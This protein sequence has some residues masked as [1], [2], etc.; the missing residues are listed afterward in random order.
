M[1]I[2]KHNKT[3]NLYTIERLIIDLRFANC[4]AFAGIYA[5]PLYS[6]LGELIHFNSK[7]EQEC[8]EFVK[9]NFSKQYEI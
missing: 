9:D 6:S 2:Y 7:N 1:T 8:L 3:N 4:N 5:Y